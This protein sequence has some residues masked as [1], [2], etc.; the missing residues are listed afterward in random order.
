VFLYPLWTQSQTVFIKIAEPS[1]DPT[2]VL[3]K[4]TG[5]LIGSVGLTGAITL[6]AIAVGALTG[7][8]LF[9][10]RRRNPLEH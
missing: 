8:L 5:V 3:D 10:M 9:W 6:L 2:G 1:S 7:G 4:V